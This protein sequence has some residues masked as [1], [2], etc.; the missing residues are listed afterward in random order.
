MIATRIVCDWGA[1][2]APDT[3]IDATA[4]SPA[5]GSK[6]F[7]LRRFFMFPSLASLFLDGL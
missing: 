7:Q 2:N 3:Q 6:S 5:S 4:A 1:A